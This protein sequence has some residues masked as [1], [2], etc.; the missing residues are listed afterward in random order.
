MDIKYLSSKNIDNLSGKTIL[1]CV[2]WNVPVDL[3]K[4]TNATR[5]INTKET[6]LF[7]KK[8][9][10]K[11]IILSHFGRPELSK[12]FY[13][14]NRNVQ[15]KGVEF[16]FEEEKSFRPLIPQFEEILGLSI[17]YIENILSPSAKMAFSKMKE[18]EILLADNIRFFGGEEFND[19]FLAD[20]LA[21]LGAVYVNEAFSCSHR[22]HVSTDALAH[23]LESYAGFGFE[24]EV[25]ILNK[26]LN[27]PQHPTL[28]LI[29]GA[30][31]SSKIDVLTNLSK[32]V[33]GMIIGG[34]MANTFLKAKGFSVGQSLVEDNHIDTA[35][36]IL[37]Q[38]NCEI[39]LPCDGR[40]S[41]DFDSPYV[42]VSYEN[43]PQTHSIF[44]IGPASIERFKNK[45]S[46][47]KTIIWNGP[48]GV[49]EKENY[50]IGTLEIAKEIARLTESNKIISVAGGGD[51][52]AALSLAGVENKLTFS[53]TAG[54]AFLEWLEGKTL[55]GLAALEK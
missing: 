21:S 15:N 18:S 52:L 10:A 47:A 48:F 23:R 36:S 28:A 34:A 11:I 29:G 13:L 54:G 2:D 55:P 20:A 12:N 33:D 24:R 42:D 1:V 16:F 46:T 8:A 26:V 37:N 19:G 43:I 5:L 39:I 44:D 31:I 32:K 6:L 53:S 41:V 49:F 30:K 27:K 51:T 35:L 22:S 45:I 14:Q 40:A 9:K 25:T 17:N 4:I 7:L 38:K 50:N 3:G